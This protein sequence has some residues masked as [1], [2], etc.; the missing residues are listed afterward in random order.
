MNEV[1]SLLGI[2]EDTSLILS[3]LRELMGKYPEKYWSEL[4]VREEFP[5]SFFNEFMELG[6]GHI[7]FPREY[8]GGGMGVLDASLIL[9]EIN[10]L[11]GNA[12]FVHGQYYNTVLLN[13]CAQESMKTR[14]FP[15]IVRG[16]LKVLSLALTEPE[17]GSDTT[18]LKTSAKRIGDHYVIN[19]HKIFISRA[20]KTD[21][22]ILVARTKPFNRE[23]KA[24]GITMFL[25]DMRDLRGRIEMKRIRTMANT[26]AYELYIENVEV[27]ASN[28]IGNVDE[29][30]YCL[31]SCL[32]A[33]RIMIA[34]E[35]IGNAEYFLEKATEYART[36]QVFDKPIGQNQGVQF[37]L[38]QGFAELISSALLLRH[39]G[40]LYD[41][42]SDNRVVGT[43]A[44]IA[45]YKASE[46]AWYLGNVAMDV[47]GGLGYSKDL[48][49]E[50]KLRET[51]LFLVAPVSRNLILADLAHNVLKLPRSF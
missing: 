43:Y 22:I 47:F 23:R 25:V 1:S 4:D 51:R 7:L 35:M 42:G 41:S 27:P 24:H 19:G 33:E 11:G 20:D 46:V 14:Y 50:R 48:G 45:K 31:L 5:S 26:D 17:V 10:L 44:N 37:P 36:R 21:F 49:I 18:K 39:A 15:E 12:Y 13:K 2:N 6:F 3:S 9:R 40:E 38:A 34:S 8:G 29:G 30:F 16:N 28:V 32:N